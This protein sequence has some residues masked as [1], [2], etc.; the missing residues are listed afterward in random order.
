MLVNT[1]SIRVSVSTEKE[2][3]TI[4]SR[5][6]SEAMSLPKLEELFS[7]KSFHVVGSLIF[8]IS[9]MKSKLNFCVASV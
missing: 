2:I 6:T 4:A 3:K 5:I 9:V 1:D 7:D 8:V